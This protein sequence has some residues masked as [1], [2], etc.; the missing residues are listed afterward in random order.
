[1]AG[2]C[3]YGDELAGSGATE[4]TCL[5]RFFLKWNVTALSYYMTIERLLGDGIDADGCR[6]DC[7]Q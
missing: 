1:V 2:S 7:R 5:I 4:F 6:R 3:K